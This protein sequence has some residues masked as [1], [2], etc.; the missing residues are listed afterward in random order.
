MIRIVRPFVSL[1]RELSGPPMTERDRQV[2]DL[3]ETGFHK[4]AGLGGF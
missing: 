3:A 1:Y 2:R 4:Y